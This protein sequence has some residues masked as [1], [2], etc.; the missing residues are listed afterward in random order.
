LQSIQLDLQLCRIRGDA[1]G[2]FSHGFSSSMISNKLLCIAL[3]LKEQMK[4]KST[5]C[6][7]DAEKITN[8]AH[9][10]R[11]SGGVPTVP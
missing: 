1:F 5:L 2:D 3:C 10:R 7:E 8:G 9:R 11:Q 6:R 4:L